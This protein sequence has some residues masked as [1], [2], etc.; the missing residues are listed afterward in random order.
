MPKALKGLVAAVLVLAGILI[1]ASVAGYAVTSF[2]SGATRTVTTATTTTTTI[3]SNRTTQFSLFTPSFGDGAFIPPRH[4]CDGENISPAFSWSGAPAN[5]E[6]YVLIM[7]DPDSPAGIW[8][9]W[10]VWN[11][12]GKSTSTPEGVV[13]AGGVQGFNSFN[14][15]GYRGP[16]PASGEHR[17]FFYLYA[18]DV[19]LNLPTGAT[20]S[21][22]DQAMAG[23]I[24]GTAQV[25]GVYERPFIPPPAQN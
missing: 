9:H 19:R 12:D 1:L 25:R 2:R 8:V 7:D 3:M 6:S 13:P 20:R 24:I 4:T 14:T 16:C 23:H 11:I 18:L 5:T 15:V 10:T 22:L 17:Y 21:Q